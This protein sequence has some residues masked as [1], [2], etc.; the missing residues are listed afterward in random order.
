[1]WKKRPKPHLVDTLM[2][3]NVVVQGD[4]H[5]SGG[6]QIDGTIMGNLIA[7]DEMSFIR[8]SEKGR[9]LGEVRGRDIIINGRVEGNVCASHHIGLDSQ[10][11]VTGNVYYQGIE[12][13]MG[14]QVNGKLIHVESSEDLPP[15]RFSTQN[16]QHTSVRSVT[17]KIQITDVVGTAEESDLEELSEE[18]TTSQPIMSSVLEHHQK[19]EIL[20]SEILNSSL[21]EKEN[22][23][24][25]IQSLPSD[26]SQPSKE[27][28][29]AEIEEVNVATAPSSSTVSR[30]DISR[31]EHGLPLHLRVPIKP[32]SDKPVVEE[33]TAF[34][35]YD[36][37][38]GDLETEEDLD[39]E[40]G[41][42]SRMTSLDDFVISGKNKLGQKPPAMEL[43]ELRLQD[44]GR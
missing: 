10:A 23:L 34:S 27:F 25:S 21:I 7:D 43:P 32:V 11:W 35:R 8:I 40:L 20:E 6:I 2:S 30:P 5:F 24:D 9:V 13:I 36:D 41:E 1:M 28:E 38:L 16:I 39:P 44:P 15:I 12:M 31:T 33:A 14:A 26:G 29:F 17:S 37:I 4:V 42:S 19:N 3:A 18:Q 22:E